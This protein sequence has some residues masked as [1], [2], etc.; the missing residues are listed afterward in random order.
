MQQTEKQE[1]SWADLVDDIDEVLGLEH[2]VQNAATAELAPLSSRMASSRAW[3]TGEHR[4]RGRGG[5]DLTAPRPAPL[6]SCAVVCA[7]GVEA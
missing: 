6:G 2:A 1:I 3:R 5:R 4:G 7:P